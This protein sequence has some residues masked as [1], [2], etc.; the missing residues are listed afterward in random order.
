MIPKDEAIAFLHPLEVG[1][2]WGVGHKTAV[3]LHKLGLRTVED[4]A[5]TPR[6]VLCRS[7]GPALGNKLHA[8]AW[9][10]EDRLIVS[11][12]VLAPEHSIGSDETFR[13]NS[14]DPVFVRRELLRLSTKVAARLRAAGLCGRTI[15][16]KVRFTDFKTITRA[17][18]LLDNTFRGP[19]I[20]AAAT[21]LYRDLDLGLTPIRLV[22]VRVQHLV[23][24]ATVNRQ[25]SLDE[26]D[27]G[28]DDAETAIDQA[29][30]KFGRDAVRPAALISSTDPRVGH[31]MADSALPG[32]QARTT[33]R[34]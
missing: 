15:T 26:R 4:L 7:L 8:L 17:T 29:A 14:N 25:L 22:G 11:R 12:R 24:A 9:G 16:L 19:E 10:A 6:P 21:R 20:Y 23:D 1:E 33:A 5:N 3:R 28:W 32:D 30:A 31:S 27:H 13:H 34:L 2:L 18:T